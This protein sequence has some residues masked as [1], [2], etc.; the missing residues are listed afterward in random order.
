MKKKL[1]KY[2]FTYSIVAVS[3]WLYF[4]FATYPFKVARWLQPFE[5]EVTLLTSRVCSP[6]SSWVKMFVEHAA[7]YQGA[8]S[9]QVV[10]LSAEKL[11]HTCKFGYKN[12]IF[13]EQV[14]AEHRY[15]YA[16]TTKLITTTAILNLVNEGKIF[17][18]DRL[19]DFFPE[20]SE[21]KDGRIRQ[22]TI[23]HLLNHSAGFNR[24]TLKG[25]PMFLRRNTPW[26]PNDLLKLQSVVLTYPPGE[27]Q[28]YSNIGYCLLGEVIH[29][30]TSETYR[31]YVDREFLLS[32]RNIKFVNNY[33]YSDE[34]R[35]D[36]RYEEWFNDTYLELF[37]F[38]AISSA[39]G[40]SGSATALAQLFWDIHHKKGNSPFVL[41]APAV[42]CNLKKVTGCLSL[43]LFHYQP[44][45]YG[46]ALHFHEGYLPGSASIA[47]VDSFGGVMVLLK[48]G[49]N[50]H[51]KNPENEWIRWIYK[52]LSLY[53]TLQ[54]KVPILNSNN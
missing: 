38:E 5:T 23:A 37:D 1:Y 14:T 41:S 40:L 28:A 9:A 18:D 29:R 34:V 13:G 25:D 47:I 11:T 32:K 15:R 49:A 22:I 48:S 45:E 44:E 24:L 3:F 7:R 4:Q 26:C 8:Y 2:F 27:K 16:S 21:F 46:I 54:G 53:Y 6:S 39:A 12:K 42:S 20:L 35:Y 19:V 51:Q 36:Y 52:R 43:G 50:R 10:F 33:Y 30:V 17:L 31:D